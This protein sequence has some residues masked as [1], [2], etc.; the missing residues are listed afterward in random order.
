[1][2]VLSF[3]SSLLSGCSVA[4]VSLCMDESLTYSGVMFV[5]FCNYT[6]AAESPVHIVPSHQSRL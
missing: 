4:C 2:L 6:Q 3:N 5:T 1:M